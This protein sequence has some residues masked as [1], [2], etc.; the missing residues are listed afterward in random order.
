MKKINSILLAAVAT[1]A[2]STALNAQVKAS[3]DAP[4]KYTDNGNG[5]AY[6]KSISVPDKDGNYT[7]TLESFVMGE[8]TIESKAIPADI[9]LV[10]DYS[11]SMNQ[12]MYEVNPDSPRP[13]QAYSTQ[14]ISNNH[15]YYKHTDGKYYPVSA[16]NS[17]IRCLTFTDDQ[18]NQYYLNNCTNRTGSRPNYVFHYDTS[19]QPFDHQPTTNDDIYNLTSNNYGCWQGVLYDAIDL[20]TKTRAL[21]EAVVRFV[22]TIQDNNETLGLKEGEIGNRIAFVLYDRSVYSGTGRNS[23][24]EVSDLNLSTTDP[25]V[26]NYSG[27]N[28]LQSRN[29]SGTNTRDAMAQAKTILDPHKNDENRTR[30]VVMFTDGTPSNYGITEETGEQFPGEGYGFSTII[31]NGCISNAYYIKNTIGAPVYS[32]GLFDE[33]DKTNQVKTYME[34]TSSD[35]KDKSAMPT[36]ASDYL[37]FTQNYGK[38]TMIVSPE[39]NLDDIFQ[40]ISEEQGGS[41]NE[42]MSSAVTAVDVVSASFVL[43]GANVPNASDADI[44][45]NVDLYLV[46]CIGEREETYTIGDE[47]KHYLEFAQ[48]DPANPEQY[49]VDYHI[50]E[51]GAEDEISVILTKAEGA[52]YK[53][54]ISVNG[55]D[56][57]ENWCGPEADLTTGDVDYRGFKLMLKIKIKMDPDATGGPNVE[58]NGPGSGIYTIVDGKPKNVVTF[59]SPTVSLPVNIFI[60]KKGLDKGESAQF[61]IERAFI[62]DEWLD[63]PDNYPVSYSD[64]VYDQLNWDPVT[65]VF[66]TKHEGEDDD[67]VITKVVGLPSTKSV[68]EIDEETGEKKQKPF[69]YRVRE[70]D[71]SWSYSS[72][73]VTPATTDQLITNPFIFQNTKTTEDYMIRHAESKATNTFVVGGGFTWDDSKTND[74]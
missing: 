3:T 42:E 39:M 37:E 64:E 19:I 24:I 70:L 67:A 59:K 1:L 51:G 6:K 17:G 32:I 47:T 5:V 61:L 63:N 72:T 30:A 16:V 11:N 25:T 43:P 28:V 12:H 44:L 26:V 65:K 41:G 57:S 35:F 55:F 14:N 68:D 13:E 8:V 9:V 27:T 56:Y 53:N 74:R 60:N 38:Y 73:I 54:A 31:A 7:I 33:D 10:L 45:K 69:V 52:T 62:P 23:L 2:F 18:G 66:V 46:P 4:W 36:S 20:G 40:F 22:K 15:Y 71:W 34:Y 58:T 29:S 49:K 48:I 50:G 21:Q